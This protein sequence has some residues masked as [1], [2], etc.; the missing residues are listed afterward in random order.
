MASVGHQMIGPGDAL[1]PPYGEDLHR[2]RLTHCE[3]QV[4]HGHE[5][6]MGYLG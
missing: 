6:A 2:D 1:R 4:H 5:L 3:A